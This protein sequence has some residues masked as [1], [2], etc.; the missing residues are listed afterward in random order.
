MEQRF[1]RVPQAAAFLGLRP[2]TLNRWRV[3]GGKLPFSR[4]GRAIVYDLR[5]LERFVELGCRVGPRR[6]ETR[7]RRAY[8][9]PARST[10]PSYCATSDSDATSGSRRHNGY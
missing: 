7:E 3:E 2:Q 8:T 4:V 6:S 5:D 9:R 10:S 1:L